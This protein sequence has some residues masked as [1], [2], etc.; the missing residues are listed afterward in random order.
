MLNYLSVENLTYDWG[1]FRLFD[2]IT[3]GIGEG[4]KSALIARNGT[5]KTTLL[6]M[7]TGRMQPDSGRIV[8]NDDIRVGYLEQSPYF[9][10]ENTVLQQVFD[11]GNE[12]ADTIR[13]YEAALFANNTDQILKLTDRMDALNAWDYE[14]RIK[15]ILS[16]LH[17]NAFDQRVAT[18]SGGQ[19]KRVALAALLISEPNFLI[20]DE[21]TNHLDLDIIEWLEE[22]LRRS[23]ITLLMVTHDRYFLDRVCTDI[24]ELDNKQ[25][26][27]YEG[28]YSYFIE[29]K[30][31]RQDAS[32]AEADKARNLLRKE[33]DWMNRQ[34]QAR[35][36]KA[37]YRIDAYYDLK[38]K[39]KT[40]PEERSLNLQFEA[41]RLGRKVVDIYGISKSFDGRCLINDFS[42]KF[43]P[44]EKVGIVGANGSGKT[45][46][47]N[48]I[49]GA[50]A[51]DNGHLEVGDTVVF[52]YYR[53]EGIVVDDSKTVIEVITDIAE[54][55]NAGIKTMTAA[56]FLRYFLFPNEMHHVQVSKLSGGERK[57]LY[58]LTILV[59]NPNFLILDEPTNDLDILTLNVLEE[60]LLSFNGTVII[61][62]HDRFFVDKIAQH[63]FV[64]NGEGG[65]KDFPGNYSEYLAWSKAQ[66]KV[67]P[68]TKPEAPKPAPQRQRQSSDRR[69]LTFAERKEFERIEAEMP[70]LAERKQQIESDLSGNAAEPLTPQRIAEL[71]EEYQRVSADLDAK[72]M[73]WLELSEFAG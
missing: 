43:A 19:Q 35:A 15:Q 56:Q 59:R 2:N 50:L 69:R 12:V 65:I 5:G 33:Q 17:I 37:Q 13:D 32:R 28:N 22:Y 44:R 29:K 46:L 51:P 39:A 27:H 57:R 64:L 72:E 63:L 70:V 1:E 21:P 47:L 6:N 67:A 26:Y 38:E 16:Q 52:G 68:Q 18:L 7:L 66:P 3:F 25:L 48:M 49:T 71:S 11:C 36:T 24:Y 55:V 60:Y 61:V 40:A 41:Q 34:P 58:L 10:N 62:S 31:E 73:R 14:Q 54:Q 20:L 53:Q 8:F 4:Q 42:Y 9:N 23:N 30:Q 45:T